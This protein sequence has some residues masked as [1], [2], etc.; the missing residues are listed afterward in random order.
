MYTTTSAAVEQ[1]PAHQWRTW[2]ETNKATIIDVREPYEWA[3]GKLPST[4]L[5]SLGSLPHRL[6]SLDRTK[7]ILVVCRTG[8]RSQ[9][10]ASFLGRAGFRA[11]NLVG[12]LVALGL[13]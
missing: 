10:A 12:G 5:I 8:S 11:A 2:A 4:E 3:Q 9:Q 1:V 13:A 7:P 6:E